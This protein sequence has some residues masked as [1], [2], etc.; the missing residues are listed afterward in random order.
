ME[1]LIQQSLYPLSKKTKLLKK[2]AEKRIQFDMGVPYKQCKTFNKVKRDMLFF[3]YKEADVDYKFERKRLF[4]NNRETMTKKQLDTADLDRGKNRFDY[5]YLEH[6]V[7]DSL[8][9]EEKDRMR[10][11]KT[12]RRKVLYETNKSMSEVLKLNRAVLLQDGLSKEERY[13][14][15][16]QNL[17]AIQEKFFD[18]MEANPEIFKIPYLLAMRKK[19]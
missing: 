13:R 3:N 12:V 10:L 17:L 5:R 4:N 11:K 9:R 18:V 19:A 2:N 14:L 15:R 1:D 6:K 7:N 8:M 16:R